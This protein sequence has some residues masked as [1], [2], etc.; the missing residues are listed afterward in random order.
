MIVREYYETR[1]DGVVL[2]RTYSDEGKK[3]MQKPTMAVYDEAIDIEGAPYEYVETDEL[4][5]PIV[6]DDPSGIMPQD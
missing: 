1:E 6:A 3:I 5:E 4:I 2:Y